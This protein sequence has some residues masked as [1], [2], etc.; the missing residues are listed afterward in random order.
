MMRKWTAM[1]MTLC[2]LTVFAAGAQAAGVTIRTFTPFADVDFAAQGYMD[3]ITAWE[4]ETGNVV[5][6]YSGAMD[7]SWMSTMML[8]I[9]RGEADVV[10][11]F[12]QKTV[13][14]WSHLLFL[15]TS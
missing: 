1:M 4:E 9:D 2:L 15:G 5:E 13:L 8:M 7:E 3:M 14:P 11:F 6:D 12:L 10:A